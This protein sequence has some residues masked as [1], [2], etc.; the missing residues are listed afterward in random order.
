MKRPVLLIVEDDTIVRRTFSLLLQDDYELVLA[1]DGIKALEVIRQRVVDL[2]LIDLNLPMMDGFETMKM[3]RKLDSE[4]GFIVISAMDR[5][6]DAVQ[7]LK[8]GAYDYI[9]KPFDENDLLTTIKRYIDGLKLKRKVFLLSEELESKHTYGEIISKSSKMRAIFGVINKVSSTSSGVLIAGESGTG[10]ELIA[11]AIHN[12]G[13]RA[14]APFVA[15]NCGAVPYELME[16]ELFG[17]EKGAF[18]GA[19]VKKIGKFEYADGG[20]IF[21]DEISTM[22]LGL[23]VKLLRVLQERSFERV[24]GNITVS[25]D[26]R[27]IAATNTDLEDAVSKGEFR[28]DL[29]YRLNV[30]PITLPPLRERVED[31]PI[32]ID[33]FIAIF[34]RK[35][36][37]AIPG[38]SNEAL[39]AMVSY[40]WP[41][42]VRELENMIERLMVYVSDLSQIG[43]EDLPEDFFFSDS[44]AAI[45]GK[46]AESDD[47]DF[48]QACKDFEKRFI[49]KVLKKTKWNRNK[50]ASELKV[51]RN[52]L[53]SKMREYDLMDGPGEQ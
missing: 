27:V 14:A 26:I 43:V 35:Y 4:L 6:E 39:Q 9:T 23:Q 25:V 47:G 16:S 5:A 15:V 38:I 49:L 34:N 7:A 44:D 8:L 3:A 18:T 12:N 51:H 48:R 19:H 29:F 41:G 21:L 50:T 40:N 10:K 42:N 28:D 52:T 37:K 11:R 24:G 13:I 31:I 17:H 30:V 53:L 32:L 33:H 22:P 45:T 2:M 1:E 20:T 46:Q 36:K